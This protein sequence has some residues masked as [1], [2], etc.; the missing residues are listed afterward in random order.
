MLPSIVIHVDC[1]HCIPKCLFTLNCMMHDYFRMRSLIFLCFLGL[2]ALAYAAEDPEHFPEE[3][4]EVGASEA[5][6]VNI[7]P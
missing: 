2:A 1:F 5:A 3:L 4:V 7:F 6:K